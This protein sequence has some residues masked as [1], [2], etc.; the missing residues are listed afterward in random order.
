MGH[1]NVVAVSR[2]DEQ[3]AGASP[4]IHQPMDLGGPTAP[5]QAYAL[6]E[7]PPLAPAAEL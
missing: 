5:R 3:H 1:G 4:L 6:E 2:A 7:G